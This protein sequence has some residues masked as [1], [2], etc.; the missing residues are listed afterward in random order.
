MRYQL[1]NKLFFV[2]AFLIF[3]NQAFAQNGSISG[4]VFDKNTNQAIEFAL[5]KIQNTNLGAKT[6]SNGEFKIV[7]VL[8]GLY[9]IEISSLSYKAMTKFEI[10]VDNYKS[11]YLEIGL[12]PDRKEIKEVNIKGSKIDKSVESPLSLKVIGLNE[13]RRNPGGNRDISKVIQSLPG[14][15]SSVGFRNDI[16]I[17]GGGPAENRFYIDGIEI[18]NLNHFSTQGAGGGPV[19]IINVD[20]L[21]DVGFFSGAFP[22]NRGNTLSSVFDFSFKNPQ[23]NRW[24]SAFTLGSSDIGLRSEGPINSKSG[25]MISARRSYLQFLFKALGLPFLP[26]YND[27]QTKFKYNIDSKN[28]ISFLFIGAYDDNVLNI[29]E[30]K[31]EE[32]QYLLGYLPQQNQWN[33]TNGLVYKHFDKKGFQTFVLSRNMLSNRVYKYKNNLEKDGLIQ[34]FTSQE[35]ENKF[36]FENNRFMKNW[37]LNYGLGLEN[38]KYNAKQFLLIENANNIFDTLNADAAIR[39]YKYALFGQIG[40]SFFNEKLGLSFGTRLDGNT[41]FESGKNLFRQFSPRFSASY[42]LTDKLSLNFN[43]GIYYQLPSYTILGYKNNAG[44]YA[45]QENDLPYIQCKHLIFGAEYASNKN[46]RFSIEGFYKFYH[47]YPVSNIRNTVLANEG[48]DFGVVGNELVISEGVGKSYGVEFFAQ[49]KLYK[50]FYG[51]GALTLFRSFFANSSSAAFIP[52][53]WD[54]RYILNLTAGKRLPK[55]WELGLK[56]RLTG[57]RPY[58][59]YDS[60]NSALVY[61]WNQFGQGIKNYTLLNSMRLGPSHQMDFRVDKKWFFN[62][63][64]LNLFFDIQNLYSFKNKEQDILTVVRDQSGMPIIQNPGG[65][66][67]YYQT[68]FLLNTN[69]TALPSIGIIVEY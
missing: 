36:R 57:G 35:I 45:N 32:Q 7:N 52:S 44:I 14:A 5:V 64:N 48:G 62:K 22:S 13:I 11:N 23:K 59:P 9:N 2:L 15:G 24:T 54:Q 19:G 63:W 17:R 4:R 10:A 42:A 34:D 38:N 31:T 58:T 16:I 30:N 27:L 37:S 50:G 41:F 46:S 3:S 55:N 56:F 29:A 20:F 53:A 47:H 61:N 49:Q 6:D 39:F 33:Y 21:S 66:P 28:E 26:T 60:L 69:G 1:A 65:S 12:E 43:T 67:L 25:L 68:K 51:L 18:P 8:P 40:R